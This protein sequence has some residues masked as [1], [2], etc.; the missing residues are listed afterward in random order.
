MDKIFFTLIATTCLAGTAHAQLHYHSASYSGIKLG[1]S[2]ATFNGNDAKNER[3]VYGF[4]AGVFANLALARPFSLQP[5]LLFSMKGV[6]GPAGISEA[7][8][9]L[10]YIDI[11]VALRVAT[12]D[13]F[14]AEA[15]PQVG[16]LL[17]AKSDATG[18]KVNVKDQ[19]HSVDFGYLLG[20]GYQSRK[21]GLGIGGRYNASFQNVYK[22]VIVGPKAAELSNSVFQVYLSY[23]P[24]KVHKGKKKQKKAPR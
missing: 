7:S 14:F 5:E 4:N 13:G 11:P 12:K 2:A 16:F 9:W 10:N 23:S 18:E 17:T 19:Y 8:Q 20:V 3:F 22:E 24:S 6:K 21:G 1:G 15:G